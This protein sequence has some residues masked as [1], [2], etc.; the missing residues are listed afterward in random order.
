MM[1]HVDSLG[2]RSYA[3][4]TNVVGTIYS[5][6]NVRVLSIIFDWIFVVQGVKLDAAAQVATLSLEG[7]FLVLIPF[8]RKKQKTQTSR[9]PVVQPTISLQTPDTGRV[10]NGLFETA[11]VCVESLEAVPTPRTYKDWMTCH[12]QSNARTDIRAESSPPGR[13]NTGSDCQSSKNASEDIWVAI[14]ADL[15]SI[16][17]SAVDDKIN[18][19]NGTY[20]TTHEPPLCL[21]GMPMHKFRSDRMDEC[22][23]AGSLIEFF[24]GNFVEDNSCNQPRYCG[25]VFLDEEVIISSEKNNEEGAEAMPGATQKKGANK[26]RKLNKIEEELKG[27]LPPVLENLKRVFTAL[28]TVYGFLQRQ[29]MQATWGN[30]KQALQQLCSRTGEERASFQDVESLATLCPKAC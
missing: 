14:A 11:G 18:L 5:G 30:V 12:G 25:T 1:L 29:H 3:N 22:S 10:Q 9:S 2:S 20:S 24:W 13:E 8:T 26:V 17:S 21:D 27:P 6:I 15:A 7:E 4:R 23:K 16:H 28:N 19:S